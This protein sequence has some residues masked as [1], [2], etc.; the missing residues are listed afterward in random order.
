MNHAGQTL[1]MLLGG[2]ERIRR[3]GASRGQVPILPQPDADV[4][5]TISPLCHASGVAQPVYDTPTFIIHGTEDDLVPWE[6]SQRFHE[7]LVAKGVKAGIRLVHRGQHLFDLG[8]GRDDGE[9]QKAVQDGYMFLLTT[10]SL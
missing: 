9:A 5:A 10:V 2:L 8:V 3:A 4:V 1:P 6:Q 7:M